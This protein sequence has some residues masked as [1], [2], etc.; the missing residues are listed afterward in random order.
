MTTWHSGSSAQHEFIAQFN[1][2]VPPDVNIIW[3]VAAPIP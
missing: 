1:A 3:D 2:S